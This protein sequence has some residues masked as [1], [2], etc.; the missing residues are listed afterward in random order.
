MCPMRLSAPQP[1]LRKFEGLS[2]FG[3][4][5]IFLYPFMFLTFEGVRTEH[6]PP[7][8]AAF[9]GCLSLVPEKVL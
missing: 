9:P 6:F 5:T 4:G 2:W 1:L 8:P 3:V 7:F